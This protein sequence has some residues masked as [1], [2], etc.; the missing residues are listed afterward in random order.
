[1]CAPRLL[2]LTLLLALGFSSQA[3]VETKL[4]E[5]PEYGFRIPFFAG[6]ART[7]Y[8][9]GTPAE[10]IE[11]VFSYDKKGKLYAWL[12]IFPNSGCITADTFYRQSE[13]FVK[14]YDGKP[15]TFRILTSTGNTYPFGWTGYFATAVIDKP[16]GS[17]HLAAREFQGFTNGRMMFMVDI[18]T[19]EYSFADETRPILEEPGYTSIRIPHDLTGLNLRVFTRGNVA[20]HYE[21][22]EK[23]YYLGR[24]DRLGTVYPFATLE[25]LSADA[26]SAALGYLG[27]ARQMA[28]ASLAKIQELA[29]EGDFARMTGKVYQVSHPLKD[30]NAAGQVHSYFF[31][32]N[33]RAYAATLVVPFV[34][35]DNQVYG[36]QHNEIDA[37]TVPLFDQ[38]LRELLGT[39]ESI[40]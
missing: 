38:R 13:R 28:G 39:V 23:K 9:G 29:N 14:Q 27:E 2:I 10:R 1:M 25:G 21:A 32:F 18:I 22:S 8:D 16:G 6:A 34:K 26:A 11:Y 36:Y 35:N 31:T 19:Q 37:E 20:S 5:F 40:R 4:L 30:E 33:N 12:R 24:C 3:Q 15:G 17:G 7:V